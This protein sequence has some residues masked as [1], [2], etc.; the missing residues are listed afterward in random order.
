MFKKI[1]PLLLPVIAVFLFSTH[2]AQANP[3][4]PAGMTKEVLNFG[5]VSP[6]PAASVLAASV[7][8]FPSPASAEDN[9]NKKK[10]V[11]AEPATWLYVLGAVVLIAVFERKALKALFHSSP[12]N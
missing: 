7:L 2:S 12:T 11:A 8:Q 9:K 3:R 1:T 10:A 5:T 4:V 6:V